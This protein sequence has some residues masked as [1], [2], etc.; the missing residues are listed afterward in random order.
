MVFWRRY[1]NML[2]AFPDCFVDLMH[3]S[4]LF[5]FLCS[6][7]GFLNIWRFRYLCWLCG[8]QW[9][10][11][12]IDTRSIKT[13]VS[14]IDPAGEFETDHVSIYMCMCQILGLGVWIKYCTKAWSLNCLRIAECVSFLVFFG[15]DEY[16]Y[17]EQ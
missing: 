4:N 17:L 10:Q 2:V 3:I 15:F 1:F 11:Y 16:R 12:I 6:C 5:I 7:A 13:M 8:Y 9:S 14:W